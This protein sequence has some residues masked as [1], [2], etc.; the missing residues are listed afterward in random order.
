MMNRFRQW[1]QRRK[2][3]NTVS[4]F[5]NK[6]SKFLR[7]HVVNSAWAEQPGSAANQSSANQNFFLSEVHNPNPARRPGRILGNL[8]THRVKEYRLA[9]N[10]DMAEGYGRVVG[11]YQAPHLAVRQTP[12]DNAP[13]LQSPLDTT[14]I[15]RGT[16]IHT[17]E[18]SGCSLKRENTNLHHVQPQNDGNVLQNHL[19]AP[20]FG[21]NEYGQE[22]RFVMFKKKDYGVKLYSQRVQNGVPT[23][24][25]RRF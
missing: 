14:A 24:T 11:Q 12:A 15:P 25:K 19:A 20:T 22:D 18:L 5:K 13:A 8:R 16:P 4:R 21:K 2:D 7:E 23:V 1:N 9:Q 17:M 6:P 3:A 10:R